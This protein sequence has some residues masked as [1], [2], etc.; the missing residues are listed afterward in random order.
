MYDGAWFNARAPFSADA[1]P[2]APCRYC[3]DF[4]AAFHD[5]VA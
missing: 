5:A 2:V 3:V 4:R 1:N